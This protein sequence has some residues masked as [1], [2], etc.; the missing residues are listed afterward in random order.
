MG[1][2]YP[3]ARNVMGLSITEASLSVG[4]RRGLTFP[5]SPAAGEDSDGHQHRAA[6]LPAA[7]GRHHGEDV[8]PGL[9]AISRDQ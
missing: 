9:S 1:T 7:V 4:V 8:A 5:L 6:L 2:I 3:S